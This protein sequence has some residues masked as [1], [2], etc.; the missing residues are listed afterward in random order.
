MK[1]LNL[2]CGTDIRPGYVNLDSAK[3]P[4]VDVVH[5]V[6]KL[7]L[8]FKKEE[9]N[10]IVCQDVLEH[11][12]RFG[13]VM[14]ELYRILASD[15]IL[16]IRVPHFTSKNNYVDPTHIQRFSTR[17]FDY[18][19]ENSRINKEK[20]RA[21]YYDFKFSSVASCRITFEKH[22]C[23]I[24][25]INKYILEPLVNSSRGAQ[26]FYESTG[27]SRIF[28]AQNIEITLVK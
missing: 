4:G 22:A 13:A 7:P 23:L 1:K 28:P 21:Y 11:S 24:R 20:G 15:G 26:D 9:F 19:I 14:G 27:F 16:V 25:T 3:L 5:D 8:P 18:F 17:T 6:E 10:E 2:G 12:N